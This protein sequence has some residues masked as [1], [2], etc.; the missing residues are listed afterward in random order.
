[1]VLKLNKKY[2]FAAVWV[3]L[4][5]F[6]CVLALPGLISPP[7]T[8]AE[9]LFAGGRLCAPVDEPDGSVRAVSEGEN[10]DE[11]FRRPSKALPYPN[12]YSFKDFEKADDG[13]PLVTKK[14]D[15]P[16]DLLLAY[17]GILREASNM[18]GYRGGC[19]TVGW[20]RLPYPYAYELLTQEA[21]KSVTLEAFENSFAGTGYTTLLK[22]L[23]AY[24]PTETPAGTK[25]YMVE[26]E[27]IT[28]EKMDSDRGASKGSGFAYHYG[29]I[30]AEEDQ[31]VGFK[32][33]AIN[34]IPED[35][36][37]APLHGWSYLAEAVVEIVYGN[38]LKLIDRIDR[39]EHKGELID[40][41]ASGGGK[42]YLFEFVRLTNGYDVL[43]HEYVLENGAWRETSLLTDDW[44][45]LKLSP[46]NSRLRSAE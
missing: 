21:R 46:E 19:G 12:P 24:A 37:C 38:N 1:M 43:L 6:V 10:T 25:Y 22:L 8:S 13:P 2:L 31:A 41:Y 23:P 27:T 11:R 42:S 17:Y 34:Y 7:E 44:K 4:L 33:A 3:V 5:G 14:F 16:E 26:L 35:F 18:V 28:G 40:V 29:L 39:V 45:N 30:T 15:D 20:S 9:N 36:L 32:I